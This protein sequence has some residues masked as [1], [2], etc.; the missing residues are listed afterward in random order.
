MQKYSRLTALCGTLALLLLATGCATVPP[1]PKDPRDP[2]E[3]IN[4]TTFAFDDALAHHVALPI[5]H[6]YRAVTPTF[7]RR[8]IAN[9][10][11]N[12]HTPDIMANDLLQGK[13]GAFGQETTRL[14][15]NSTV[16]LGGLLD[17]AS[18]VGL[19]K[20]DNDFGRTLGTWGLPPGPYFV[21]PLM[22][23]SD[24]RDA[25]GK[26]PDQFAN[27]QNYIGNK[28]WFYAV[29]SLNLLNT[30]SET[31]IPT[32]ELL[33]QQNAFDRYAF[34]RNAYLQRREFQIHGESNGA[35]DQEEKQLQQSLQDDSTPAPAPSTK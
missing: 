12:I 8:G 16:G 17:P 22:G 13:F 34:A 30:F 24:I 26:I 10:F 7:V 19:P 23:P 27:P 2:L 33:D 35:V 18:A 3:R 4:R 28:E 1:G 25:L 15:L 29:Y 6:A 20:D 5:G 14:V 9:F 32:Y 21:L 11:E 31:L